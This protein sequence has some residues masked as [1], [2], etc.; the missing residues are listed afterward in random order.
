LRTSTPYHGI[1]LYSLA[2]RINCIEELEIA[3]ITFNKMSTKHVK[4]LVKND[5]E[6]EAMQKVLFL[7]I[8]C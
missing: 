4:R 3:S 1:F 6:S 7:I 2:L 5:A 8:E